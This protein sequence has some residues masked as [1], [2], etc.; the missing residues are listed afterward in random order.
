MTNT[1][2]LSLASFLPKDEI[3]KDIAIA[4]LGLETLDE[5]KSDSLD[6]SEQAVWSLKAALA[7]AYEAGQRAR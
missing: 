5:R 2:P 4:Y 1:A 7:A 3:L 6:F